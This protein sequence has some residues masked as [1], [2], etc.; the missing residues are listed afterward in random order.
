MFN[1]KLPSVEWIIE[2]QGSVLA[3]MTLRMGGEGK[4]CCFVRQMGIE[5]KAVGRA[6]PVRLTDRSEKAALRI[7]STTPTFD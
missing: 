7:P 1:E 5:Q 2:S 6:F 4:R 3:D